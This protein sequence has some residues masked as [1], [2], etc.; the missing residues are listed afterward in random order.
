MPLFKSQAGPAA[1]QS[2][3]PHS[4]TATQEPSATGACANE[5]S[6]AATATPNAASDNTDTPRPS[7]EKPLPTRPTFKSRLQ[8]FSCLPTPVKRHANRLSAAYN[9]DVTARHP[10][11][12]PTAPQSSNK[13]EPTKSGKLPPEPSED[14]RRL[15]KRYMSTRDALARAEGDLEK[16]VAKVVELKGRKDELYS[17]LVKSVTEGKRVGDEGWE[18]RVPGIVGRLVKAG[19]GGTEDAEE[20]EEEKEEGEEEK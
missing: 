10:R 13:K 5:G 7:T 8:N 1:E 2:V 20:G 14:E 6:E 16:L 4:P 19:G 9:A 12:R 18:S 3:P 11:P 17:R 15:F